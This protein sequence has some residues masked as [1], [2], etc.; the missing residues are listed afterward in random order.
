MDGMEAEKLPAFALQ[1]ALTGC[2]GIP[3]VGEIN[4]LMVAEKLFV[5]VQPKAAK[6]PANSKAKSAKKK[7]NKSVAA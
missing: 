2:V 1:M 3:R 6:K 4:H 7:S 5:P